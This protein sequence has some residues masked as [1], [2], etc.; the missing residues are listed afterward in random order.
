MLFEHATFAAQS[1]RLG[2]IAVCFDGKEQLYFVEERAMIT[3]NYFINNLLL[4]KIDMICF[5]K[6][7]ARAEVVITLL[8]FRRQ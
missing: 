8:E 7:G 3:V 4:V 2:V 5:P 6:D 1:T